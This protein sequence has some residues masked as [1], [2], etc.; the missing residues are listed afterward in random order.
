MSINPLITNIQFG[1]ASPAYKS[2]SAGTDFEEILLQIREDLKTI[3]L[4]DAGSLLGSSGLLP[5]RETAFLSASSLLNMHPTEFSLLDELLL[6]ALEETRL[7]VQKNLPETGL[8]E[9]NLESQISDRY[10]LDLSK[11]GVLLKKPA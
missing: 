2:R 11:M 6:T 5:G 3:G 10:K 1:V 7:A 4:M 9:N 8:T